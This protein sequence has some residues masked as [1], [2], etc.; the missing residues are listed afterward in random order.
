MESKS[1]SSSVPPSPLR[2]EFTTEPPRGI[3]KSL[4]VMQ[5]ARELQFD[6]GSARRSLGTPELLAENLQDSSFSGDGSFR[7]VE[8]ERSDLMESYSRD[9]IMK[10][11]TT[12]EGMR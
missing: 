10:T 1:G 2:A 8:A 6:V 3:F 5:A 9:A 12:E 7:D 11:Q 4:P